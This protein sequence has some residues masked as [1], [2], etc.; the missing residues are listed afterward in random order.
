ML[1]DNA[2][3]SAAA[4][5]P[6]DDA[7]SSV[8]SMLKDN[9]VASA[10]ASVPVDNA[11][12]VS[13]LEDNAAAAVAAASMPEM[14]SAAPTPPPLRQLP[15]FSGAFCVS[16]NNENEDKDSSSVD[17]IASGLK[18]A[19]KMRMHQHVLHQQPDEPL[20]VFLPVS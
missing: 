20:Q 2:A 15:L 8:A 6:V 9:A 3:T 13:M 16:C 4:S 10:A 11:A 19:K 14:D 5:M 7:A 1:E 12:A 17:D 18:R